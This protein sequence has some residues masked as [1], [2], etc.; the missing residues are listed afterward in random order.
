M[1]R[2]VH[3][4]A[5]IQSARERGAQLHLELPPGHVLT[6][7]ARPVFGA[8]AIAF[9]GTRLDTLDTLLREASE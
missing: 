7:L 5:T 2:Q 6:H 9:D 8:G 3:W 4:H 1:A